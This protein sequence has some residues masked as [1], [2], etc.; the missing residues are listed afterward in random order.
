MLFRF[1]LYGFLKNQRYFEPFLMLALLDQGLSFFWIGV[2]IAIRSVTI[3]LLEIPSGAIA[4]SWGRRATMIVGFSAY[5]ISFL[6][7]AFAGS[8][9]WLMLAMVLFGVGDSFRTGTH[10]AMI[11]EWLRL[12]NRE[13]DRT[14]VY[15]IT[16]SWSKFGSA[17]SAI[18][19][20]GFVIATD[21]YQMIFLLSTIPCVINVVNFLGYPQA[22]DG[23][24]SSSSQSPPSLHQTW[25]QLRTTLAS[26]FA[27]RPLRRLMIESI[28][29][30]GVFNA[31]KDY[32]QP[33]IAGLV[34]ISLVHRIPLSQT[35]STALLVGF[36]Y[37]ILFFLGGVASRNADW[38]TKRFANV[39]CSVGRLWLLNGSIFLGLATFS[40]LGLI[41]P[42]VVMFVLLNILQNVWRPI[43]I[44]RFDEHSEADSGATLLSVESGA[45][46]LATMALAPLIGWA[47]DSVSSGTELAVWP[48][49]VLG[50]LASLTMWTTHSSRSS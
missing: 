27:K 45:Q 17:L 30:E 46:R 5:T 15:G 2:L 23:P 7:F 12:Q 11:F 44:G 48:L 25:W 1:C 33:T 18:L 8:H 40:W 49:G 26:A 34:A 13:K 4:D 3:N 50:L 21:S 32:V 37:S 14:L 10:K 43:L 36:V 41:W 42:V 9:Y 6:T 24:R 28:C 16:R 20:A 22:L 29:W 38:F 31:V 39:E 47:I 35:S 19:A